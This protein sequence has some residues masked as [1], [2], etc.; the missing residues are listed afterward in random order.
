MF[1]FSQLRCFVAVAI[2]LHFGRAAERLN[3]T[4]PPLSRQIQLL[5][6]ELGVELLT[7]GR[8]SVR[9][10]SAGRAFLPEAEDLL[11]RGEAAALAARRALRGDAGSVT[12]GF[13]PAASYGFLPKLVSVARDLMPDVDLILKELTTSEQQEGIA[14]RRIDL[15]LV[16]PLRIRHGIETAR[17]MRDPFVLAVPSRHPLAERAHITVRDLDRQ[18]FIMYS[19]AEG[20]Y[21]YEILAGVF[22][23]AGIEPL[24]VQFLFQTHTILSLVGAGLGIALVPESARNARPENVVLRSIDVADAATELH[25]AWLPDT[26][27]AA[28]AKLRRHVT[29]RAA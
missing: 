18:P 27:N 9:L 16:R 17:V 2:E 3:M 11:R 20:R 26:D 6:H 14:A 29:E 7:R 21:S 22:R 19:P 24:Y 4:Q 8:R 25:L 10:T 13:I 12:L 28:A 15:G 1:Q 23:A 5:E